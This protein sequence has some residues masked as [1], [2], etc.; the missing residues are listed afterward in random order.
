MSV[1]APHCGLSEKYKDKFY[2]E[3]IAVTS[4]FGDNG[5]GVGGGDFNGHVG[6]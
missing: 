5:L 6:K 1:Y 3:L 2:D 4:R